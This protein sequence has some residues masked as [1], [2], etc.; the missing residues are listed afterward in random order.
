MRNKKTIG[1]FLLAAGFLVSHA[2]AADVE[3]AAL[4]DTTTLQ[5]YVAQF[6][7]GDEELYAARHT[8]ATLL[9]QMNVPESVRM[10]VVGHSTTAAHRGYAH[11]D[12]TQA[13]AALGKLDVLMQGIGD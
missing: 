10:A 6:N 7:A 3:G 13:R 1:R 12:L 2:H 4:L 8:T 9:M 11:V 5:G